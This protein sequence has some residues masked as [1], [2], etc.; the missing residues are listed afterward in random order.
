M[1]NPPCT[2][3]RCFA[4][5]AAAREAAINCRGKMSNIP[6]AL[7]WRVRALQAKARGTGGAAAAL[8]EQ[9]RALQAERDAMGNIETIEDDARAAVVQGL[10]A[11]AVAALVKGAVEGLRESIK[12]DLSR[13]MATALLEAVE[14]AKLPRETVITIA[15]EGKRNTLKGRHHKAFAL[16]LKLL[17]AR[18]NVFM[19]GPAASGKSTAA[20]RAAEA[21]GLDYGFKTCTTQMSEVSLKGFIDSGGT[22]RST[23]FRRCFE[24]GGLFLLDEIDNGNANVLGCLNSALA[25]SSC[26]FPDGMVKRHKDFRACGGANTGG[27]G[28]TLEYIGRNPIDGA[29]LDRFAKLAFGYDEELEMHI[30]TDRDPKNGPAW[31]AF[32][33]KVRAEVSHRGVKQAIVSPRATY[34]GIAMIAEGCTMAELIACRVQGSMD[35]ALMES[36]VATVGRPQIA[37]AP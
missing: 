13:S 24:F 28:K 27:T 34:D 18:V 4:C 36:I 31:C 21:L 14:A 11:E 12:N 1:C 29:T 9:R 7:R 10:D 26:D 8:E 3:T 37:V 15:K 25:G 2:A 35:S 30:A 32:V 33:Q 6:E 20:E 5:N 23:D 19:V 16:L 22:Y 17:I